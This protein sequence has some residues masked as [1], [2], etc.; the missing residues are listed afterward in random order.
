MKITKAEYHKNIEKD[1]FSGQVFNNYMQVYNYLQFC[2]T[3]L[4]FG[5]FHG[6]KS[7]KYKTIYF[8][9]ENWSR[10]IYVICDSYTKEIPEITYKIKYT[11]EEWKNVLNCI[12]SKKNGKYLKFSNKTINK[13]FDGIEK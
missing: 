5:V 7:S 1:F 10:T 6:D 11:E 3:D 13:V 4:K 2:M 12:A 9:S 8:Y